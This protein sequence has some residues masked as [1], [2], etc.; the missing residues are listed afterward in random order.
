MGH[1]K[2]ILDSRDPG[3]LP[4]RLHDDKRETVGKGFHAKEI[5]ELF[6]HI[7][8]DIPQVA[9]DVFA[10]IGQGSPLRR[11]GGSFLL[12]GSTKETEIPDGRRRASRM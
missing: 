11:Q 1:P 8:R 7:R 10:E 5:G 6:A 2:V 4:H 12:S 9:S 3:D